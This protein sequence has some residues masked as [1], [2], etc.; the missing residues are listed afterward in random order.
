[1][2]AIG[3][4]G[5]L[6]GRAAE[7]AALDRLLGQARSGRPR[8]AVVEAEPGMGKT[9]MLEGFVARHCDTANVRWARCAEFEQNLACGLVDLLVGAGGPATCS[10]V[11]AGRRLLSWLGQLQGDDPRPVVL[12]VD[13]AQWM[14]R[15]SAQA[16][17]FA[18]RRLRA[19]R[20]LCV[21]ARRPVPDP[22]AAMD[23]PGATTVLRPG[24]L[25]RNAVHELA[26]ALRSWELP[27]HVV[28]RLITRTGGVPLLVTA[29]LR[30]VPDTAGLESG[31]DLP[32]SVASAATRLLAGVDDGARRLVEAAAVLAEPA[33]LVVLGRIADVE[34]PSAT[35]TDAAACGL[36]RVDGR[37]RVEC[38]HALLGEAVYGTLTLVRRRDLHARA[39]AWTSG[40]RCLAH[41]TAAADRSDS[42]L[43]ADLIAAAD[44]ARTTLRYGRAATHRLRARA[45]SGDP[46]QRVRL[47]LE[48]LVERVEAQDLTGARE[49]APE[50]LEASPCAL[51]SLALGLLA[52]DGG[53]IGPARTRLHEAVELAT[54]SGDR[55][56]AARARLET[57]AMLVRLGDGAAAVAVLPPPDAVD[58]PGLA[59]DVL[60]TRALALWSVGEPGRALD[61]VGA[62]PIT[63]YGTPQE[64]DLLGARGMLQL[65]GGRLRHALVDLDAAVRLVHLWRPSTNQSRSYVLRALARYHLGDWDGA[66]VDAAAGRALA[67]GGPETWS[68]PLALAAT[69]PVPTQRGQWD[70]AAGYLAA[71]KEALTSLAAAP[72]VEFVLDREVDLAT[73]RDDDRGVLHLLAPVWSDGYARRA[74]QRAG[75]ETVQARIAALARIGRPG[76]AEAELARYEALLAEF[77]DGPLP[78]RLG[79]L[80]GLIAEASGQPRQARQHYAADLADPRLEETPFQLAQVLLAAGRLERVL[81]HRRTAIMY[82]G[83]AS[84][85]FI[86]LRAAPWLRRCRAELATCDVPSPGPDP[87]VLTRREEDVRA[88]VL[89]GYTNKEVASELFLTART[90]EYHLRNIYAKLG[91]A[92]RQEL[93]RMRNGAADAPRG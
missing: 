59:T 92:S 56:R 6:A 14:D 50:A 85:L 17:R 44:A 75:H 1:M 40:D 7:T 28:E 65:F 48:A 51:R 88:L 55:A 93:R 9:A 18:L 58:D 78:G 63:S 26:R 84:A 54:T 5:V 39:A 90:V 41:R 80:R 47:L 36:V 34:D 29:V 49:L 11:D 21:L 69:A 81:G 20:V 25:S 46:A 62:D 31:A 76:D 77:P 83:R 89:R 13:D 64:A 12:A 38:A 57:A 86:T 15:E 22:V 66:S 43:V 32:A 23:V 74:V 2:G 53:E 37:G 70:V 91:I 87:L 4:P 42:R 72:S 10:A 19:D 16:L 82:L 67:Q 79:W 52:R 61:L 71:A 30:G 45:I 33:D 24:P 3:P 68:A 8:V 27:P 60:T 73:A 35:V